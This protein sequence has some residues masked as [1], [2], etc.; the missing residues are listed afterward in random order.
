MG[1]P[2]FAADFLRHLIKSRHKVV[3]VA[4]QPD[5]PSGR[6]MELRS[7]PVKITALE[8]GIPVLQPVSVKSL[9]FA[10]ELRNLNADIFVVV[11]FSILPKADLAA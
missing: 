2:E 7:P 6:G 9:E 5:K 1:T 8:S 10:E 4:T 3:A 11:A